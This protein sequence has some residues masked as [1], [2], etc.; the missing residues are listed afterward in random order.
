MITHTCD[1]NGIDL[2]NKKEESGVTSIQSINENNNISMNDDENS[3]HKYYAP[4]LTSKNNEDVSSGSEYDSAKRRVDCN[5]QIILDL[6]LNKSK[7]FK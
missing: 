6:L 5:K 4:L 2:L 7:G 3:I 1:Y